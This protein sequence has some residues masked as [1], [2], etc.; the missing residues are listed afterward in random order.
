RRGIL[1]DT[2]PEGLFKTIRVTR[3]TVWA[4]GLSEARTEF[5]PDPGRIRP[6]LLFTS[7][8]RVQEPRESS[9]KKISRDSTLLQ[10][11]TGTLIKPWVGVRN[12]QTVLIGWRLV[13]ILPS[14]G[15]SHRGQQ[16]AGHDNA[17]D[18]TSKA[19]W[20]SEDMWI[21][22]RCS[23]SS[24]ETRG[25]LMAPS[26]MTTRSTRPDV[27][28]SSQEARPSLEPKL[29]QMLAALAE[30]NRKVEMAHEAILGLKDEVAE[31]RRDNACLEGMLASEARSRQREDFDEE[32]QQESRGQPPREVPAPSRLRI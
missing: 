22:G 17:R 10:T 25:Q 13:K 21:V 20:D 28:G 6:N 24:S 30:V 3:D 11:Q 18:I 16:K 15:S 23:I 12:G 26:R 27:E 19:L 1:S 2:C 31:V 29:D 14:P 9:A 4:H 7:T 8:V 5:I 32:V